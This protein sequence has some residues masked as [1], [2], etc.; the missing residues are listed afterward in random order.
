[1]ESLKF[2]DWNYVW[3][4][5]TPALSYISFIS[6]TVKNDA[7]QC[8]KKW[9]GPP[10][11]RPLREAATLAATQ[12]YWNCRAVIQCN[13]L[14]LCAQTRSPQAITTFYTSA[15]AL[16]SFSF[17]WNCSAS[18]QKHCGPYQAAAIA[19][20]V[21]IFKTC[22]QFPLPGR[23]YTDFWSNVEKKKLL[24]KMMIF[25]SMC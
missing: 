22:I 12:C 8:D 21:D 14:C 15:L 19:K 10:S 9:R 17:L 2:S 7:F 24:K 16:V 6:K 3:R 5:S 11:S 1:M 13:R 23:T 20:Y 4:V 25:T 18:Q